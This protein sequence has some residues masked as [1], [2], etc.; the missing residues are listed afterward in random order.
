M[1][2]VNHTE[3]LNYLFNH[4]YDPAQISESDALTRRRWCQFVVNF[5]T[6]G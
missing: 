2:G 5:A 3:E 6:Y 1:V 4:P